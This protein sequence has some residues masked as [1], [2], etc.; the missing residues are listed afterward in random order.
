MN[1]FDEL[2]KQNNEACEIVANGANNLHKIAQES[3]RVADV[4]NNAGKILSDIDKEFSEK[5]RLEGVDLAFLFVAVVLQCIRQYWLSNDAFRFKND[6]QASKTIKKFAPIELTGSVPYDAFKK[7]GFLDN[8]GIS[9]ANHRQTAIGHDPLLGWVFGTANILS[10]TVTKN[11][12][13][14]KTYNTILIGNEYKING[15]SNIVNVFDSS[16]QRTME[17]YTDLLLA[18]G[19]H[20]VHLSSDAFTKMGL[21]I[22][23][24]NTLC[25]NLTSTLLKNGIDT[26]SIGRGIALSTFINWII[27]AVHGL[28]YNPDK[29]AS[30]DMYEVK[31]RKI[32]SYSNVIASGSNVLYVAFTK[33]LTKLD[34]GGLIVTLYRIITDYRFIQ[35]VKKEFISTQ[36]KNLIM[37]KEYDFMMEVD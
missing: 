20:A 12:F 22:P 5:T 35:E 11:D 28:F 14:L 36:Y 32:L 26:Y 1:K 29:Y 34:V 2:R 6:Q 27:A 3:Y 23:V 21:P 30:R 7:E 25:P 37:G 31:T 16:F 15:K 17:N 24:I 18:V 33:D 13:L 10:E 9:G 19:K 8:T 4:A